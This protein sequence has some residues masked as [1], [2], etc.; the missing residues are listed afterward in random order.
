MPNFDFA[1]VASVKA[2]S[3]GSKKNKEIKGVITINKK[4]EYFVELL[5]GF[6]YPIHPSC[7]S[8]EGHDVVY[9]IND[10]FKNLYIYYRRDTFAMN[11]YQF[12]PFAPGLVC[13]AN[14][15]DHKAVIIDCW[16]DK[17]N[18][19]A[20]EAIEYYKKNI[21]IINEN[22]RKRLNEIGHHW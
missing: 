18:A 8:C 9:R 19:A 7:F 5:T 12:L 6:K 13:T 14:I 11:P 16:I 3:K 17:H 1:N 21:N 15:K 22:I 20:N 2:H 10:S 4:G